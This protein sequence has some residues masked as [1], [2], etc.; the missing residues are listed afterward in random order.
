[1]DDKYADTSA[2]LILTHYIFA[3]ENDD[4]E[5]EAEATQKPDD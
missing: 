2:H 3:F 5:D 4:C 1:M